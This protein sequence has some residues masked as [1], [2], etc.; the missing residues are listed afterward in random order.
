MPI[1]EVELYLIMK[2]IMELF[3]QLVIAYTSYR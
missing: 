3:S 1:L 2:E